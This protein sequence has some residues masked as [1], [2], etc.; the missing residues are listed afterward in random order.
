MSYLFSCTGQY[1]HYED[2]HIDKRS[3]INTFI[4]TE[5]F[6]N[7]SN[8]KEI[9]KAL[10]N[11]ED[12]RKDNQKIYA[13]Y[14]KLMIPKNLNESIKHELIK[15]FMRTLSYH[16]IEICYLY[17]FV[18]EGKGSYIEVIA[19]ERYYY[20]NSTY[21][22]LLYKR[23]MYIDSKTGRTTGKDNTN[24][25]LRCKKGDPVIRDGK[26]ITVR[27]IVSNKIMALRYHD[28]MVL[29]KKKSKFE[30][31]I[32]RLKGILIL[33]CTKI[34]KGM[35][36]YLKLPA[37]TYKSN[38]SKTKRAKIMNYNKII[39]SINLQ[40]MSIQ[41]ILHCKKALIDSE[42]AN[43]DFNRLFSILKSAVMNE[44]ILVNKGNNYYIYISPLKRCEFKQFKDTM[45]SFESYS[46]RCIVR[47]YKNNF[48]Y[49][50][51]GLS[52]SEKGE[53]YDRILAEFMGNI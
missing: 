48:D 42:F 10:M 28:S 19:F 40:L 50:F 35:K 14:L 24:A 45:K 11:Y 16:Y 33:V 29:E 2:I 9:V 49:K 12:T 22:P 18:K 34:I 36:A 52:V 20:K 53:I 43:K 47:W 3:F 41:D 30:N 31:F 6:S 38:F 25:I 4:N 21:K 23:D 27:N 13:K 8:Y 44:K 7:K 26:V 1:V 32:N 17:R 37:K 51:M 46:T 15:K 39:N 5:C